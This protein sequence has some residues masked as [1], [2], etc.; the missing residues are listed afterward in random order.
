[1]DIKSPNIILIG[2]MPGNGKSTLSINLHKNIQYSHLLH[3]DI[4]FYDMPDIDNISPICCIYTYC[5]K[6][7]FNYAKFLNIIVTKINKII[8]DNIY[9]N[10]IILDGYVF[11]KFK[12]FEKDLEKQF[13]NVYY[14]Q[15]TK[16]HTGF[17]IEYN[18]NIICENSFSEDLNIDGLILEQI[19]NKIYNKEKLIKDIKYQT[20]DF[21]NVQKDSNSQ[22]KLLKSNLLNIDL[23]NKTVMDIGCNSGY[24]CFKFAEKNA[25]TIYGIDNNKMFLEQA[26]EINKCFYNFN[27]IIFKNDNFFDI[28]F[29][30]KFDLIFCAS[31]YHYFSNEQK[32]SFFKKCYELLNKNGILVIEIE[33]YPENSESKLYEYPRGDNSI[34]TYP[35]LLFI[36]NTI[37]S[38]F[39]IKTYNESVKQS[40]SAFNRY[41]FLL[42][43]INS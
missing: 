15:S 38:L 22:N 32:V 20:F 28:K 24:F 34:L 3:S 40:G 4:F 14:L 29:D 1:M 12:N 5:N 23:S 18:N 13:K 27:N 6:P 11:Y 39:N 19:K 35:S 31:V 2:G 42:E 17:N 25:K 36:Q 10:S 30:T 26:Y 33:L 41:F 16:T 43:K 21:H 37:S 7:E 9:I 8:D